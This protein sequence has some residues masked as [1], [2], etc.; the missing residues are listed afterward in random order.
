V[1]AHPSYPDRE[2]FGRRTVEIPTGE[3]TRSLARQVKALSSRCREAGVP[4]V[5]VKPHG[6][7]YHDA[8]AVEGVAFAIADAVAEVDP[9]LVLVGFA[10]SP[11]LGVWRAR[12]HPVRAEG[13]LDRT[14]E[15][16]GSLRS[17][18]H[19][20]A[21]IVDTG[22][23]PQ[24]EST[25]GYAK[26]TSA[27]YQRKQQEILTKHIAESDVV[28]TTALIPGRKAPR[29]VTAEMAAGMRPGSVIIDMAVEMGGNVEGSEPGKTVV[30][31]GVTIVGELN[32]PGR[33][34]YDS[35]RMFARN[36][37]GFLEAVVKEGNLTPNWEDEVVTATCVCRDGEITHE[38]SAEA[39][40]KTPVSAA[41]EPAK[42][43][44]YDAGQANPQ[45]GEAQ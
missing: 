9:G 22:T 20:D 32:L 40:G 26:E 39:L 5:H 35:S 43:D 6:A 4:L 19:A 16:D 27:E 28:I 10:G 17:R 41:P 2:H 34:A 18:R 21:L 42:P 45:T 31:N 36:I 7:L 23:P 24:A 30:K 14:Y 12:G 3:L 1:G 11:A 15:A 44:N 25:G 8:S 13:F 37:M 38:A 33:V 29:L